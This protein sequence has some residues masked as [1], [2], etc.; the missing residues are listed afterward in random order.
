MKKLI[1]LGTDVKTKLQLGVDTLADAVKVT[2]GPKG[3]NVVIETAYG[4]PHVTKDGVTVANAIVL[5]DPVENLGA[6]ILKQAASKTV[7]Q[8]GDGTTTSI[9][10]AQ[11]MVKQGF[12][13]ITAGHD[14]ISLI[15][16]M[17]DS[18]QH[19]L[20][21]IKAL[22]T[23]IANDWDQIEQIAS[24]S[25]NNDAIIG[26]LIREGYETVGVDG[27]VAV[28]E[29][30]TSDTFVEKSQGMYWDRGYL[31][32]YFINNPKKRSCELEN[33]LIFIFDKK[34]RSTQEI[35]PIME[36][37]HSQSRPLL[38]IAEEIEAQALGLLVVNRVKNNMPVCAVKAPGFGERRLKVL[39]DIAAMTGGNLLSET[40]AR[41]LH[42][43][44]M[45]D[46]GGAGS[47]IITRDG[48]TI[49]DGNGSEQRVTARIDDIR[50]E[51]MQAESEYD[52]S[53]TKERLAKMQNGIAILHV[54]APTEVE[55]KQKKDR[56]ED[57]LQAT[58]AALEEGIVPGAG[59][60]FISATMNRVHD[61]PRY[62]GD[63][64]AYH[65]GQKLVD[66]A[67]KAPLLQIAANAG[68]TPEVA[69]EAVIAALGSE[70]ATKNMGLNVDGAQYG[71]KTIDLKSIGVID[72]TKVL[73]CALENAVS[74]AT[75]LLSTEVA[76]TEID[77][78]GSE[79]GY[80]G[81]E[82]Y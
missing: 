13:Q 80:G 33:P 47:V 54:G 19:I 61:I 6:Q 38:I 66:E 10:L 56:V 53:A 75:M 79:M 50:A 82:M 34:I 1:T 68:I 58:K 14:S 18:K 41:P 8:A 60:A 44:T 51:L 62:I 81:E 3:K 45:K 27:V 59:T 67:V 77:N 30:K 73:L 37:S 55:L 35:I 32:P 71:N 29:S 16:G 52:K 21:H 9:V 5:A 22:S 2:L 57:A 23:N 63:P 70:G 7:S 24:I 74:V 78:P 15:K 4:T 12:K 25:A 46:F 65:A 39:E 48:F 69:L 17:Q 49:I 76:I 72:P 64:Q 31:S 20:D 26:S 42:T 28:Q 36:M 11:E 43:A 40:K